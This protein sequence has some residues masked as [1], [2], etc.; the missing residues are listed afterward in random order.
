MKRPALLLLA[1]ILAAREVRAVEPLQVATGGFR[2]AAYIENGH[3]NGVICDILAEITHRTGIPFEIHI[4]PWA[5]ALTEAQAGRIDAIFPTYYTPQREAI[6]AFPSE[7]LITQ[8]IGL[9]VR[10][11][12]PIQVGPDLKGAVGHS[13][14]IINRTSAGRHLDQAF[15]SGL[16][17]EPET[18]PDTA[19]QV[20]ILAAGRVELIAG[21][22]QAIWAEAAQLGLKDQ[23]RELSP[24]VEEAPAYLAFTRARDLSAEIR[25]IDATLR[26]MKEDG[27]YQKI[28]TRYLVMKTQ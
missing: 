11:E 19:S 26:S 20:R 12:S 10:A 27:S 14:A 9:F 25:A 18:A 15:E 2:P 4:L 17:S 28:L 22:D 13:I 1:S 16:L 8:P 3:F 24:V 6:Y 5:R 21:Y 7:I 23:I